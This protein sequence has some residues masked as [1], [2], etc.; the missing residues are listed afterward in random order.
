MAAA[1]LL[2]V[3]MRRFSS[4]STGGALTGQVAVV[5]GAATV[6]PSPAQPT[7]P[8]S[9]ASR[10]LP[11]TRCWRPGAQGLGLGMAETLARAGASVVIGDV[12]ANVAESAAAK[13]RDDGLAVTADVLDVSQSASVDAFYEG[14]VG[15]HGGIDISVQNAGVGQK[16]TYTT[17]LP[18]A[19]WDRVVGI[20]LTGS[21]YCC[22]AAGRVMER[23]VRPSP[24][25]RALP[26]PLITRWLWRGG[27]SAVPS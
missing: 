21:F 7:H 15:A 9:T 5:T 10:A 24:T 13:L 12:Q 22:R 6:S 16:V 14:V 23:Q 1:R 4:A 27:R 25:L 20:T 18:D 2:G 26:C 19:E 8:S 3:P 11:F 17:E